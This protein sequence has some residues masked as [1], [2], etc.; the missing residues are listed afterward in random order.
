MP[1]KQL[2]TKVWIAPGCIVCDACETTAPDVFEVK[3]DEGTCLIRPAALDMEFNKPRTQSIID[4][5]LECPVDVIKYETVAVEVSEAE[6]AA[7]AAPAPAGKAADEKV[8]APATA[9]AHPEKPAKK[10]LDRPKVT[11][12]AIQAL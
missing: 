12:P 6:A 3:H 8:P 2:V 4:A 10:E 7:T 11:D 1:T 9:K 5:A